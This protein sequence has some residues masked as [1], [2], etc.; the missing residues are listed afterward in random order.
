M[1]HNLH[2]ISPAIFPNNPVII[3]EAT[4][5]D[6]YPSSS[7][8]RPM[9]IAVVIDFGSRVMYSLCSNLNNRA[10]MKIV[11]RLVNTP[12]AMPTIMAVKFF[13]K[14]LYCSY[15]GIAKQIVAGVKR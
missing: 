11:V 4:V 9:P 15:R 6:I 5:I 10:M 3:I 12:E 7:C 14:S 2:I 8:E 1:P 13:F